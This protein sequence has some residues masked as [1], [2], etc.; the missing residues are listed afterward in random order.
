MNN[1][2]FVDVD[3]QNDFI[4]PDGK[5]YI[6]NAEKIKSNIKKLMDFAIKSDSYV[7]S[8]VDKHSINDIEFDNLA[9]HCIE[10]TYGQEKIP[11]TMLPNP[12]IL[13]IK[14][15]NTIKSNTKQFIIE[16]NTFDVFSNQTTDRLIRIIKPSKCVV[17]GVA[18][19]YCV[20]LAVLGLIKRQYPV[21]LVTDAIKGINEEAS[22]SFINMVKGLGVILTST[23]EL[24]E[25]SLCLLR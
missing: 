11:E 5:L 9:P 18:T 6:A 20:K 3:T 12:Q 17:F 4:N 10:N 13:T 2:L 25:E 15:P 24:L 19:D 16:K 22:L 21:T 1:I 7:L 14:G 23:E 8:S